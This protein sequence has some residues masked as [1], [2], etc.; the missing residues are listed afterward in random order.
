MN[1]SLY[2][3]IEIITVADKMAV[4]TQST[5]TCPEIITIAGVMGT[6]ASKHLY[7]Y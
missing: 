3:C 5:Y 2:T 4:V 1:Q 6:N 7:M